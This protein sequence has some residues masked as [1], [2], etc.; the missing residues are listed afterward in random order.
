MFSC[1]LCS[2]C[3][4]IARSIGLDIVILDQE[5]TLHRDVRM[6]IEPADAHDIRN[7]FHSADPVISVEV[8]AELEVFP[9]QEVLFVDRKYDEAHAVL[10][11]E[12]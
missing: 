7:G 3:R 10:C 4:Y 1:F 6:C 12:L 11:L 8:Q 5:S 9:G 2:L